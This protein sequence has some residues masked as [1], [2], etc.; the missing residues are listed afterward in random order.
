MKSKILTGLILL[1]L[2]SAANAQGIDRVF[3]GNNPQSFGQ[4]IKN[5]FNLSD[6]NKS[7]AVV[8]GISRYKS[9]PN[10]TSTRNDAIRM[11]DFLINEAGFDYVHLITEERATLPRLR[12]VMMDVMPDLVGSN[13]RFVFYWSGH[14]ETRE[15]NQT[16]HG[17]LP[18]NNSASGEY[19]NMLRMRTLAEWDEGLS[20]KQTLY[21]LDACFS[22]LAGFQR[23]GHRNQTIKQIAR[24]SRQ[25]LTAGLSDEETIASS[26]F[27]G[28]LFT[29][30]IIDGLKGEADVGFGRYQKDGIVSIKE[31]ELY[32]KQRVNEEIRNRRLGR[33]LTPSLLSLAGSG[34]G[35]FFFVDKDHTEQQS[36]TPVIVASNL[37]VETKS[38]ASRDNNGSVSHYHPANQFSNALT[39]SHPGG[40]VP[41]PHNYGNQKKTQ[42]QAANGV[43]TDVQTSAPSTGKKW[44]EPDMVSIPAGTFT[45]GCDP[46]RDNV[47]GG[48]C[49]SDE[50]PT[51]RVSI[52][53]FQMAKTEVTFEQWDACAT[54]G[55][56]IKADDAGW[57]RGKRP[58]INVSWNDVQV[59]L[60]WLSQQTGKR[61]QLPTEAQWEYAAR[62]NRNTAY[63]WGNTINCNNANYGQCKTD[64]TKPVGT[65]SA[66]NFGL[67]DTSGNVWEW[68]Q[69]CYKDTY[70]GAPVNGAARSACTG[71]DRV[72]RGGSWYNDPQPLRSAYRHGNTP[73]RRTNKLGF[74]PALVN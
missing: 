17:Y 41:H 25:I 11:K 64:R 33:R 43:V 72:L 23:K 6:F 3:H 8:V 54:A 65:Y 62:A 7:Y 46:T 13:D 69:D 4:L 51:R 22:G 14:G 74:R 37:P 52:G 38:S 42:S 30:A 63:P 70:Q 50:Q 28:S 39:H 27:G 60:K 29:T 21:L 55:V 26:S 19:S 66:N 18:L 36:T 24:P 47:G 57:G 61:Y 44:F 56:C 48:G 49:E 32:A 67:H 34:A 1:S 10:L 68:V 59:Y 2:A 31:L 73:D 20:A 9:F 40:G 53:A 35:D 12:K 45:M 71:S 15:L 58:V 16:Q 5:V